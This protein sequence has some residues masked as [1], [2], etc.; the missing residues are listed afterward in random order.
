MG[1]E[2][3]LGKRCL[4]YWLAVEMDPFGRGQKMGPGERT[5]LR[6]NASPLVVGLQERC[7]QATSAPFPLGA[8]Y[9]DD[10]ETAQVCLLRRR[11][12]GAYTSW[13]G[14]IESTHC[15]PQSLEGVLDQ[16]F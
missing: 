6:G 15:V 4:A 3:R 7:D 14:W 16:H 8:D 5:D 2:E 10:V 12:H 11:Q 1:L 13:R 9:V